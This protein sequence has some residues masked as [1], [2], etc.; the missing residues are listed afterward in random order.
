MTD[1]TTSSAPVVL[2]APAGIDVCVCTYRRPSLSAT[3]ESLAGQVLAQGVVMRVIVADN[4]DTPSAEGLATRCAVSGGMALHYVHAPARNISVARNACLDTATAP[5][6]AFIDDDEIAPPNWLAALLAERGAHAAPIVLGPVR[7]AYDRTL[8]AW[9]AQADLHA[10]RPAIRKGGIIDTGY[11]CNV[12][13]DRAIVGD[14]R[15]DLARGRTGGEDDVF[16]SGLARAG[17]R[18]TFAPDAWL[19]EPVTPARG[20]LLWLVRRAFRN[21]QTIMAIRV[22]A[23]GRRQM[24]AGIA[25]GKLL[26]CAGQALVRA[27]SPAGWRRA[28]V[29]GALH[30]GAVARAFGK[31]ELELY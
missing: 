24:L 11:S 8:P 5:L 22:D 12:L 31:R 19:V 14:R 17:H 1:Q 13:F 25:A 2:A 15:F 6:I 4:D 26:A 3:L 7:A 29:R 16:F 10:T 27:S 9:V 28:V 21:G 20:S 18:I 30:A 23:G